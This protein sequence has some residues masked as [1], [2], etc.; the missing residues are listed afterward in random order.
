M[1]ISFN[2][3][4]FNSYGGALKPPLRHF[5]RLLSNFFT[6][7]NIKSSIETLE[8]TF[9]YPPYIIIKGMDTSDSRLIHSRWYAKLP[10]AKFAKNRTVLNVSVPFPE[11]SEYLQKDHLNY[12]ETNCVEYVVQEIPQQYLNLSTADILTALFEKLHD[13]IAVVE[14]KLKKADQFNANEIDAILSSLQVTI[15]EQDLVENEAFYEKQARDLRINTALQHREIRKNRLLEKTRLIADI[16]FMHEIENTDLLY[17]RPYNTQ[18]CDEILDKL[19][20]KK[21]KCPCYTHLYIS[22]SDT[23]ENALHGAVGIL[24]YWFVY[25]VAVINKPLDYKNKSENEKKRIVFDLLKVGLVDIASI[26]KLDMKIL[27]EVLNAIEE[28][29]FNRKI[30]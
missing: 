29:Y 9:A 13:V 18:F 4:T 25:G 2:L 1:N 12:A 11:L 10:I 3:T 19:R 28:K 20:E 7:Q 26:D 23:V 6:K 14:S 17:F 21:F 27:E 24:D 30:S 8:I 15:S 5:D 22:V 16:R